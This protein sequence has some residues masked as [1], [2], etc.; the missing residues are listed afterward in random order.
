MSFDAFWFHNQSH[1]INFAESKYS[2]AQMYS[3]PWLS[4]LSKLAEIGSS[5]REEVPFGKIVT[6]C[7][8][9]A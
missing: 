9:K 4:K 7:C 5:A 2:L 8:Q 6:F 1:A 3:F